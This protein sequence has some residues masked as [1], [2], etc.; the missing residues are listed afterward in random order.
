MYVTLAFFIVNYY[1]FITSFPLGTLL[2][3]LLKFCLIVS[4]D[5]LAAMCTLQ[6]GFVNRPKNTNL[7]Y[8][9]KALE[10]YDWC[11]EMGYPD[12][13]T[14]TG[15][16]L[17]WFLKDKVF[18]RRNKKDKNKIAGFYTVC[19]YKSA[20]IDI[21][22]QQKGMNMNTNEHPGLFPPVKSLMVQ[23]KT[24][25]NV[26]N[27]QNYMDHAQGTILAGFT[28][29]EDLIKMPKYFLDLNRPFQSATGC[30]F[31]CPTLHYVEVRMFE[32]YS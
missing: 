1:F 2:L 14:V 24:G 27:H 25:T 5:D 18:S 9:C 8:N 32:L 10:F 12:G 17:H 30:Y 22:M 20:I 15:S 28:T 4:D 13:A 29:N 19:Q 6:E 31:C 7:S 16:K 23:Y 11:I 21:Y 26:R 3:T